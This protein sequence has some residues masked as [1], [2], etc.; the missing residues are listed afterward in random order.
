MKLL[1]NFSIVLLMLLLNSSCFVYSQLINKFGIK[2][3]AIVSWLSE[4]YSDNPVTASFEQSKS[5]TYLFL[6][7]DIGIYAELFDSPK[8]CVSTELHYVNRGEEKEGPVK[9]L[10]PVENQ[11]GF[12]EYRAV[13]DRFE[14]LSFQIL[15][16]WKYEINSSDRLYLFLGPKLDYRIGNHNSD[17]FNDVKFKNSRAELGLIAGIGNEIWELLL[18][19]L[20]YDYSLTNTYQIE[21]GSNT[22]GRKNNSVSLSLGFSLKKLLRITF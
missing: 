5:Q 6:T 18:L 1:K 19:E 11:P 15:P 3:G 4:P 16:R 10:A 21:Y 22:Y 7:F 14:Y 17:G 13:S 20:R 12:Y 9:F 2:G 8:F